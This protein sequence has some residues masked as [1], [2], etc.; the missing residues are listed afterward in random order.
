M[1]PRDERLFLSGSLDCRL[2]LW[3]IESRK[4][5]SWHELGQ[6]GLITTVA[7]N[8]SGKVAIC[9]TSTAQ[10]LFFDCTRGLQYHSQITV[11]SRRGKNKK[12]SKL[13]GLDVITSALGDDKLLVSSNDSRM[14]VYRMRDKELECKYAGGFLNTS[15]QI[16]GVFSRDDGCF[17]LTAS[18]DGFLTIF[19]GGE[20][21]GEHKKKG[22]LS[23]FKSA[24]GNKSERITEYE[25]F[26]AFSAPCTTAIFA[27]TS[28]RNLLISS[29]L[30]PSDV[31]MYTTGGIREEVETILN[32][33]IIVA[34]DTQ[35][36][37]RIWE[38]NS[39]LVQWLERRSQS[40]GDLMIY[41]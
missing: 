15:S 16:K 32:G 36:R 35:G 13:S 28:L 6:D 3:S 23:I 20:L 24:G 39:K 9:G 1:H 11:C 2:R 29:N 26:Q 21:S 17:V 8:P 38:N 27:P 10:C 41:C 33:Q 34:A 40:V 14:R 4:V 25:R 31:S 30:R 22:F 37:I 5:L 7:F 12:G 19:C 18:E